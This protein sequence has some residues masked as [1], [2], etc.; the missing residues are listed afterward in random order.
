[1]GRQAR[2][3]VYWGGGLVVLTLLRL[4]LAASLPLSPDEAYYRIW[5]LAPASGYLDH[6]PMVAVWVRLGMFLAGDT[7]EGVRLLG[8]VSACLGTLLIAH[9]AYCWLQ[10][11]GDRALACMGA[12]RAG[13]LLNGTLAIQLGTLVMTPDAPL[14][15]FMALLLWA[16]VQVCVCQRPRM[17]L[18]VGLAAGLGFDSKYTVLLPVAGLVLWLFVTK[19]GRAW[20]RT[21]WPWGAAFVAGVCV[22]PV[23]WWNAHHAW[24][25]FFKQ[26]G[27]V[28]DW[29]P[30]RAVSFMGELL[31][32]Q[33]GL[34][35]PL[36]FAFF[37]GG[38]WLLW[39]RRD[40][41]SSLLL[42]MIALPVMVF[43]QHALGARVQAN[44]PVVLYPIMA[45]A[46]AWVTWPWWKTASFVGIGLAGIVCVQAAFM[47]FRLSPHMDMTLRQLGG[48]PAFA[49]SVA[50]V[51]PHD[52]PLVA[53]EYGLASELAFYAPTRSVLAVE[54]RWQLFDLP[55]PHCGLDAYLVQS[56]RRKGPPDE[57]F[58]EVLSTLP[59][60]ARARR[61]VVADTYALF[62]VR[63]RCSAEGGMYDA[64]YL[65]GGGR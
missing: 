40:G 29:H 63:L 30:A 6:P 22:S 38:V 42:C 58:F 4:V 59:D 57:R 18:L 24:A 44:W 37:A 54:P 21:P 47:P 10:K 27:R 56:H 1:M 17:W 3:W 45:L 13:A 12:L 5:A 51:V 26:G 55:R 48:W 41:F 39:K 16:L 34:A 50:A 31:G 62:H 65:P 2:L 61:G 52:A 32:G 43:V 25:S 23:I 49:Q 20:L 19:Q 14:L 15:L 33:V 46:A 11:Q 9:A 35:T 53:D 28:A 8:P 60:M 64:A 7:A 36:V